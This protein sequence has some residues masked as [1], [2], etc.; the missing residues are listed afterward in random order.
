MILVVNEIE[1]ELKGMNENKNIYQIVEEK[2]NLLE[3]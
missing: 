2:L 3:N 1:K